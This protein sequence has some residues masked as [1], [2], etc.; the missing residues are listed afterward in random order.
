MR[1]RLMRPLKVTDHFPR[2]LTVSPSQFNSVLPHLLGQIKDV[3]YVAMVVF[4]LCHKHETIY[5]NHL[6]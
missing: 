6:T 4:I 1:Y 5:W 3:L 2:S